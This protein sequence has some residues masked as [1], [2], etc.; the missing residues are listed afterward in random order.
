MPKELNADNVEPEPVKRRAFLKVLGGGAILA[1]G[2][3]GIFAATRTPTEALAPWKVAP[4]PDSSI[5]PRRIILSHAILAPNP[6]NRQPWLVDLGNKNEITLF[7]DLDR[8][9]PHT[10]PFDRQITIGLGCFLE[11]AHMTA[12]QIGYEAN[13]ELFPEGEGNP[14]LD[15]R[16]VARI[17]LSQVETKADSLFAQIFERRSNKDPYDPNKAVDDMTAETLLAQA[18]SG[19]FAGKVTD[20]ETAEKL[21]DIA[22]QAMD[23]ELR[24]YRT[25][26]ESIDLLR[27]GKAE[28]EANPDGIDLGGAFFEVVNAL[29]FMDREA[30]LDTSTTVFQQ[31]VEAIKEPFKTANG[32][33]FVKTA[34]NSRKDQ[35]A[36]GRDYVRINLKATEMGVA[37]QPWS[38]SLQEFPEVAEQFNA[39]R[40]VLG[41]AGNETLQ[42]FARIGYGE[43]PNPS[44]RWKY[45]TRIRDA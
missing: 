44:P 16:P 41:I 27:I 35:I 40:G 33:V 32:F 2:G 19:T 28:I 22:W 11:L 26:K 5:D 7:C 39:I 10:D 29:G 13:I 12:R 6:H 38:Q 18:I 31:Q 9:L 15:E 36:A 42:M 17:R 43:K 34:G 21:R 20:A 1:A 25:A 14:R 8:R 37:M 23:T 24:T 3:A 30:M 4:G 45:E